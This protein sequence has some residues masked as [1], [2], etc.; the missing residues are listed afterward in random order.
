M[1]KA[2]GC[3]AHLAVVAALTVAIDRATGA[4]VAPVLRPWAGLV[5]SVLLVLGASNFLQLL[6]GYGQG[7]ASRGT[8]L[9]RLKQF[10]ITRPRS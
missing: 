9:A 4:Q 5:A 3:L 6:R 7:D 10:G 1:M 2:L 8:L